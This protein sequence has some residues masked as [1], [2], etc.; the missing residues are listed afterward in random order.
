M[1]F[2]TFSKLADRVVELSKASDES[3]VPGHVYE[4]VA[5]GYAK[6]ARQK[7]SYRGKAVD[8]GHVPVEALVAHVVKHAPGATEAHARRAISHFNR[9]G[10]GEIAGS[11]AGSSFRVPAIHDGGDHARVIRDVREHQ[12]KSPMAKGVSSLTTRTE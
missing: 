8:A 3:K 2:A 1:D 7:W 6:L 5:A 9:A 10:H 4:H 11:G 12:S